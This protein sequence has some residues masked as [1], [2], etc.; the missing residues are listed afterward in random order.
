MTPKLIDRVPRERGDGEVWDVGGEHQLLVLPEGE[1]VHVSG[2]RAKDR[3]E[4]EWLDREVERIAKGAGLWLETSPGIDISMVVVR[5][6]DA[7]ALLRA[8]AA[9][10]SD[11]SSK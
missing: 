11:S 9:H 3:A 7:A 5:A 8:C 1:T 10:F 4:A 6:A 2:Y